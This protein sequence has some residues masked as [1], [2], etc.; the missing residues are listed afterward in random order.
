MTFEWDPR[1][2]AQNIRKHGVSF[3]EAATVFGDP[4]ALTFPDSEHSITELRFITIGLSNTSRTLTIAHTDR[5]DRIRLISARE[6]T[7]RERTEYE[8]EKA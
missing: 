3:H 5:R 6:A 7:P 4:L 1:K 8:D 2:E